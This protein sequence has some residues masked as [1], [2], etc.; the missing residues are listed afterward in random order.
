MN[1]VITQ[2]ISITQVPIEIFNG[3]QPL[4]NNLV[5]SGL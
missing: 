5:E 4:N 3:Y 2:K 1:P